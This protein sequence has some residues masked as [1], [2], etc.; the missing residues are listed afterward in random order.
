METRGSTDGQTSRIKNNLPLKDK[1]SS[2]PTKPGRLSREHFSH[3][4]LLLVLVTS[5]FLAEV[6]AMILIFA[7]PPLPYQYMTLI[8]AGTMVILVFPALY[9]LSFRPLIRH[10]EKRQKAEQALRQVNRALSVLN[11]CNQLLVRADE[12]IDLLQRMCEIIV[13]TGEYRMAW[14]GFA[15][16]DEARSV[17][18]VAQVGFEDGYLDTAQISW[19]D[20]ERGRGP[21]GRA[22]REGVTQVNQ[23]FLTN[24]NMA[25]W[26]ESALLRGYQS[27]IALP[28]GNEDSTL[29]ALT[30]YSASPEAFNEEEVH[31]LK[32]LANDLAFG[33]SALRIRAERD[34]AHAQIREMALFPIF[35]PNGVIRVEPSGQITMANPAAEEIGL[36][37]GA[38]LTDMIP[39]LRGVDIAS[40]IALG[41]TQ[42]IPESYLDERVLQW[43]IHGAPEL[44]LAFLYSTDITLRKQAED[45]NRQLSRIV[46]QTE[47]TVVVTNREGII[48]YV[49][50]AF[51][52]LTGYTKEEALGKTPRVIKSGLHDHRFYQELWNTIL[53]GNVF[54]SEIANR[55]KNG[56][57][58]YEVKTI[59]PLR[60]MQ[61]NITHF[62]ATGKNITDHK[63]DEEKLL[64]A[65]DQLELR[66]LERT[67]ELRIA[68]SELEDEIN[69]RRRAEEALQQS[70]QRLRRAQEIA[71]L[72]S[73][74]L[75]LENNV[76]T[77]SDE[78][79]RIF[80]FQP[81]EFGA[82]YEAF[83]EAVHP[84]DRAA[85]DHAYS[86]SIQ[87][88]RDSYE[89]EH[90]IVK[91]SSGEA[92][93]V[94][95]KCEHFRNETG[96]IIRSVGMVHDIT[97][98][99]LAEEALRQSEE[100]FSKA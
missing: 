87:E 33:I 38:K 92:R 18:P 12:E 34:R 10:I 49:N 74:E 75:D 70:E 98:R 16:Q 60:N 41:T 89:I 3:L 63:L 42:H 20:N 90:R 85:V 4:R 99:K 7:L 95:E 43:A 23:N 91:R 14:V 97:E 55:K 56:E 68:N 45:L 82:T 62:V 79:Y 50:P 46:E 69:V 44:R 61:G 96:K 5:I 11:E 84:D 66:V 73:W 57:L 59:T 19:A 67:E 100:N 64:K 36:R 48:E 29:G 2:S 22:I 81:Q 35:N 52:R 77:W 51:E 53:E 32:E 71:H 78:V 31:L 21:T 8:D 58:Y 47:D 26:R 28:L 13:T 83:L 80:G 9:F 15:E 76:L 93:V 65:Y 30:I 72:G 40:C 27:S 25:P 86:G 88:G 17:R 39:S 54:Q 37:V 6:M 1:L 94:H 24:P